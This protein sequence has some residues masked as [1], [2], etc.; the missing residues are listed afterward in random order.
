M[1][2]YYFKNGYPKSFA[3]FSFLEK[4]MIF[5]KSG[6]LF[7]WSRPER[8]QSSEKK[9]C[10]GFM[11]FLGDIIKNVFKLSIKKYFRLRREII[12]MI[13]NIYICKVARG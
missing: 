2:I 4:K 7:S 12:Q 13:K 5:G 8:N 10:H 11:E 3:Y 9:F 6:Y 1:V